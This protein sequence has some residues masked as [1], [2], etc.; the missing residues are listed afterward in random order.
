MVTYHMPM[1]LM[2]C[3]VGQPSLPRLQVFTQIAHHSKVLLEAEPIK[4]I[5]PHLYP[6]LAEVVDGGEE[7]SYFTYMQVN[8]AGSMGNVCKAGHS[9]HTG[10][11]CKKLQ[12]AKDNI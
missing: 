7:G 3:T 11:T 1:C 4:L 2:F 8:V 6:Y 10:M 12:T 5:L 9:F